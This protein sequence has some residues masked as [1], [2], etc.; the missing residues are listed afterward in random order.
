V[1]LAIPLLGLSFGALLTAS[2]LALWGRFR[3]VEGLALATR[4]IKWMATGL[5]LAAIPFLWIENLPAVILQLTL[6]AAI[7]VP[8]VGRRQPLPWHDATTMLPALVLA[9]IGLFLVAG[10][11]QVG[12]DAITITSL[13]PAIYGGLAARTLGEALGTLASPAAST[14]RLFDALYLLLTLAT[15]TNALTTLWQRGIVW[16]GDPAESGLLGAWL[17]WSA[18]WLSPCR[19]P[20]LRAALIVV[21]T[22]LLV[23]LALEAS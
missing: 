5:L 6:M 12:R 8:P 1:G 19:R 9:G 20:R 11:A 13:A 16:V 17:A 18:A 23:V 21:A 14:S 4:A 7:V 3:R 22:L 10:P 2:G 15:G